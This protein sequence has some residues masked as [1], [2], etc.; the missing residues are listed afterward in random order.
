MMSFAVS[1]HFFIRESQICFLQGGDSQ[2]Q[3]NLLTPHN[4]TIWL[5]V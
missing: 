3:I 5:H 2:S 4:K 1:L